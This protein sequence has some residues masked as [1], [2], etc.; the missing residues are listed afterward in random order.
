LDRLGRRPQQECVQT[1]PPVATSDA[2]STSRGTRPRPWIRSPDAEAR[3]RRAV[4]LDPGDAD[5]FACLGQALLAE[6]KLGDSVA[7][8]RRSLALDPENHR[9]LIALASALVPKGDLDEAVRIYR[10][11]LADDPNDAWA[12]R[13]MEEVG[14]RRRDRGLAPGSSP[15]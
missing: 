12:R 1:P 15:S 10:D 9:A 8:S 6:G 3:F 5:A 11:V 13:G 2:S 4:A 14:A 7:Q